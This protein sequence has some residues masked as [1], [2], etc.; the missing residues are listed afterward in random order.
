M[1]MLPGVSAI[2]A[3]VL[4]F[5]LPVS[6]TDLHRLWEERCGECHGDSAQ[7]VRGSLRVIDGQLQGK[8]PGT[9]LRVF[10]LRHR[11][12]LPESHAHAVY[13]MLLAQATT[14]PR[15]REQC[16]ICH[17][18]AADLARDSLILRN[19]D[20]VGRYSGRR[21][22]DFLHDHG[23]L[24]EAGVVFFTELLGRVEREVHHP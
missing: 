13:E 15:F 6:A 22:S 9:D 8:R 20:L 4:S 21:V 23:R 17:A 1:W 18:K 2:L 14:P 19:G 10:M 5:A 11:G 12:G 24:D 3:L 7:F 16:G